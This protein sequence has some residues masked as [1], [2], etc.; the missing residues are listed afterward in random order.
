M[1]EKFTIT[2]PTPPCRIC[3]LRNYK[4]VS[5][6]SAVGAYCEV[7]TLPTVLAARDWAIEQQA[8]MM[9]ARHFVIPAPPYDPLTAT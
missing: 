1:T 7:H 6:L 2:L 8:A 3:G 5:V 9:K 4:N